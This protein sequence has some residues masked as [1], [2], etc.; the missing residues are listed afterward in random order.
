M[1]RMYSRK[2]GKSSSTKPS[3]RFKPSWV[4]YKKR[5][6]ELLVQ[7]L[8]KD[9]HSSSEIG[10]ILRDAYGVPDVSLIAERSITEILREKKLLGAIPEDL[11]AVIKKAVTLR[12]HFDENRQDKTSFRGLQLAESRIKRLVKYY[13]RTGKIS[14]DWKYDSESIKLYAE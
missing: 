1:A 10:I 9:G 5:E 2:K 13:K 14:I 12:K 7:K 6:I 4:R 11:M 8:G 3:K